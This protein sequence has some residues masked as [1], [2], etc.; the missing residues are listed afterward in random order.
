MSILDE[1]KNDTVAVYNCTHLAL[2]KVTGGDRHRF[3]HNQTTNDFEKLKPQEGCETVFVTSTARTI[4]L[5]TAYAQEEEIL[6]LVSSS[7]KEKLM[8]WMDRYI[9]PMDKVKIEDISA[10]YAIFNIFGQNSQKTLSRW[11]EE[12]ILIGSQGNNQT[13]DIDNVDLVLAIGNGLALPGYTLIIPQNKANK[14]WEKLLQNDVIP[15][16]NEGYESLRVLQG[17]PKPDTELTEDYNPLEVGLWKTISFE[18][19]C[20]IGQE[21]IARLNTYKGVKQKL[22]GIKVNQPVTPGAIITKN[23]EKIGVITSYTET[24]N[25][26]FALGYIRTKAGDVGLKVEIGQATAEVVKLPFIT[27]Q[28]V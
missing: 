9:F 24:D 28:Y 11:V 23:G 3:L 1:V 2:I 12:D 25:Q 18:K 15:L 13:I 27:H 21:T 4:D 10:D 26:G 5:V 20:Y 14:I 16:N 19:G 22:W 8:Q 7:R 17:R 6:L